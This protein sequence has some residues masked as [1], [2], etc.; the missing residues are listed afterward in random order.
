MRVDSHQH[1]WRYNDQDYGWM[2]DDQGA[3]KKDFLPADLAP[4]LKESGIDAT[5]AVQARQSAE[6]TAFLLELAKDN[7]NI[8]GVVGWVDLQADGLEATLA[9]LAAHPKLC[10]VRHLV[11]DESDSAFMLKPEFL[12]GVA[13]LADYDL[14][15]DFLVKP[16]QLPQAIAVAAQ[17][18]DQKFVLDHIA[19]P[20]I[21]ESHM[22]PWAAHIAELASY[23]NVWSKVSGLVTE[24]NWQSWQADD[25]TPWLDH[26]LECFGANR[27]MFGSDWPVCTLAGS[28]GQVN[29]IVSDFVS[30]LSD[31][32][33]AAILGGNALKFYGLSLDD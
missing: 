24:A 12:R 19:K 17:F 3:L 9:E 16:H 4:H 33:Q 1:F 2:S 6:E 30:N 10:G 5:I 20:L 26:I 21:K 11:E 31:N 23:A 18:P 28:Y 13:A 32:D 27:L 15:Y 25:F 22:L 8:C 7:P 29:S 14:T